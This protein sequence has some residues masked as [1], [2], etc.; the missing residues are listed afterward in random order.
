MTDLT[1]SMPDAMQDTIPTLPDDLSHLIP[2]EDE[3]LEAFI[4][5]A[6]L[7]MNT[8]QL[9]LCLTQLQKAHEEASL[10]AIRLLDALC[11]VHTLRPEAQTLMGLDTDDPNHADALSALICRCR[12]AD[13]RRTTPP[14]QLRTV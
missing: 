11:R 2:A 13:A 1:P 4:R 6:G 8:S 3:A 7:F 14:W 9:R 5:D 10:A 12:D